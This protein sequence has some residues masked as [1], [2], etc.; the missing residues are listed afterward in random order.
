VAYLLVFATGIALCLLLYWRM[1]LTDSLPNDVERLKQLLS[2]AQDQVQRLSTQLHSRDVLIEKMKLQ[3]AQ[4]KRMKFGR[5]SEQLDAQIDQLELS[6]EELEANSAEASIA[7]EPTSPAV[8]FIKPTRQALPAELPRESHQHE[9]PTGTCSCPQCGGALRAM[10]EDVSEMLE[11]VPEHWKVHRHIRPKYSCSSCESIVQASA[12]SRPIERGYAGPGLLAHV[13][14][15]KY[16]DHLPLYRQSQIYARGGVELDRSTLAEWV[17]SLSHLIAPLTDSLAKYVM[18]AQKLHADDTPIPVLAPGTDKTKTGRL[19]TYVRDDQPAGSTD[20]PAALFRYSP[21]RKGERPQVHLKD[22][23][24]ILQADGYA[25]FQG[26]YDRTDDPLLE[27][28]CWAHARRKFFEIHAATNSPAALEALE[29]IGALYKIEAEIRGQS[30]EQR[31]MVRQ[32]HAAPRLAQLNAWLHATVR[33]LSRKSPLAG[34]IGYA[35]SRWEA[36]TRYCDDGRIEIDNNAAERALRTVALG[37]KNYLFAGSD[38]GGERA[39][40]FYSLIGTAKLNGMDPEAYLREVFARIAE[41]PIN[42]IDEL[43]PWNIARAVDTSK[44][45]SAA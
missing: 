17:G 8:A 40:A 19:W 29:R 12:P 35:L 7:T 3:L 27:A 4:L 43:L 18:G 6:L 37:R 20:P 31:K 14:V 45:K 42:R 33:P 5:S 15:S 1:S 25:G 22:F 23:R 41:H 26:L 21:D 32:T 9:P 36:L 44:I 2:A 39:A 34:A 10:G 16:C 11:Y 24:G 30:P 28:A 38:A 13:V